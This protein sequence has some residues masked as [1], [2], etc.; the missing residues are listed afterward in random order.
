[1]DKDQ[2]L[3]ILHLY[4]Q[5]WV[6]LCMLF[7]DNIVLIEEIRVGVNVMLEAGGKDYKKNVL[8]SDEVKRSI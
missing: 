1:M 7:V 4:I 8:E 3:Y 5:I 6:S 2:T